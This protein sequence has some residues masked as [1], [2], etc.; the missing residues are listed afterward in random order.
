MIS[1][2][3][4]ETYSIFYLVYSEDQIYVVVMFTIITVE[5]DQNMW[6][7]YPKEVGTD[8]TKQSSTNGGEVKVLSR[9]K[10]QFLLYCSACFE[11]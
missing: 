1:G 10:L 9:Q 3:N 8:F 4:M 5:R 2:L 7:F 6:E 11:I